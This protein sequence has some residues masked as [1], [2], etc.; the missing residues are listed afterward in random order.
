ML[1][2]DNPVLVTRVE[3]IYVLVLV[4]SLVLDREYLERTSDLG[5]C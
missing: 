1:D 3:T 4:C 2:L 5:L